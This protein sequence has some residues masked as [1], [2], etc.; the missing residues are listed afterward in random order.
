MKTEKKTNIHKDKE[1]SRVLTNPSNVI[2]SDSLASILNEPSVEKSHSN[3]CAIKIFSVDY[4]VLGTFLELEKDS[5]TTKITMRSRAEVAFDSYHKFSL[6]EKIEAE[7]VNNYVS[8]ILLEYSMKNVESHGE[9]IDFCFLI[10][11]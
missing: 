5:Q 4:E 7:L 3:L 8:G 11:A 2:M 6:G 1:M 9:W 10:D